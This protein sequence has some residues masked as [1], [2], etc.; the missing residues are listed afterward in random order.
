MLPLRTLSL[1]LW[2]ITVDPAFIASHQSIK[3][4]GIWID[5]LDHVPAVM[6]TYFFLIFSEHHWD[7]LC[8]NLPHL[9]FIANNCVY[10]SHTDIKLCTYC[11]Y[12]HATVLIH[13]IL[14]LANQLWCSDFLTLST[15]L[16]IPYIRPAFLEYLM[17][18]KI[19]CLIH[20]RW[21]KSR[22]K[23][24]IRFCGIFFPSLKQNFIAYRS[25]KVSSRPDYIFEIH[26]LWQSGFSRV[27]SN[28]C[29]SCSFEPEI[30]KIGQSFNTMDRNKIINSQESTTIWN[31]SIKKG[32]EAYW[33]QEYMHSCECTCVYSNMCMS[34]FACIYLYVYVHAHIC[35]RICMCANIFIYLHVHILYA[36]IYIHIYIYMCVCVC[37]HIYIC[38]F[39]YLFRYTYSYIHVCI[40][41]VMSIHVHVYICIFMRLYIYIYIYMRACVCVCACVCACK[42][43]HIYISLYVW[44]ALY[45]HLYSHAY[46]HTHICMYIS[47]SLSLYIYI[48][49]YIY[50]C[51]YVCV[52]IHDYTNACIK[53]FMQT[54]MRIGMCVCYIMNMYIFP[55]VCIYVHIHVYIYTYIYVRV[56]MS[57][58]RV[59]L[60][61]M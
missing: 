38:T 10:S 23:H 30:I 15:P 51:I 43:V 18:L 61:T 31:A 60:I 6:K 21:S 39:I 36:Y 3:N 12:R 55:Y 24:S 29:C 1:G 7:K 58:Y 33:R 47:L 52:C 50:T 54:Y 46:I 8:A 2:V 16:I 9:K 11:L 45:M 40:R 53:L 59:K 13:D 41:V 4:Y 35:V 37:V 57:I 17:Q 56:Y 27:Y 14:Y 32:L 20:A 5:Q 49:I 22:Q 42:Y 48:Y 28:S 44:K 25:S 34:I 19:W 26:Q